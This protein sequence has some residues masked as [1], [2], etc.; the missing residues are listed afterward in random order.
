M[1]VCPCPSVVKYFHPLAADHRLALS[2]PQSYLVDEMTGL[3]CKL[4]RRGCA[5]ISLL[6]LTMLA[7]VPTTFAD[8]L[9][10]SNLLTQADLAGQRGHVP[11]AITLY[12]RAARSAAGNSAELCLVT[13]RYCDL[14]YDTTV[15]DLQK[16]LAQA[17]L[18]CAKSAVKADASNA[19]AHLCVAVG[20]A[21]NFPYIDLATKVAW[22]KSIK[23]EGETAIALDP[24][25]DLGYY[26]LGRW[27]F[28][29]A[30][31][32]ILSR[33]FVKVVYGGLPPASDVA[34][35]KYFKQAIAL[36][37]NR[38][39]PRVAL[40]RAYEATSQR[41]LAVAE[42]KKCRTLKPVDRDDAEAQKEAATLLARIS[43]ESR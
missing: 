13:R 35:I 25:Q 15:P 43:P 5:A 9:T 31:L 2:V 1:R 6:L 42:L 17:A 33:G 27:N 19:I 24:K 11:V 22:S 23:T 21:K 37:P 40:A 16:R 30:N 28:D 10:F 3:T 20:Y 38:I 29:T 18:A 4:N 12:D 34:A 14:M 41:P 39:L 7:P 32:G 8:S 26:L 36:A